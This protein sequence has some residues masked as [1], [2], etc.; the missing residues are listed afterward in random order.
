MVATHYV[1]LLL[2]LQ[3]GKIGGVRMVRSSSRD[4]PEPPLAYLKIS[5]GIFHDMLCHD[6]DMLH[7]LTGEVPESV[8]S[9]AHTHNPEIGKMDD[10]DTVIVTMKSSSGL[11]ATVDTSRISAYGYD[12]RIEVFGEKGM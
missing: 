12:Q 9:V 8:Y 10:A 11:L 2:S 1:S 5:G 3:A 6:F 4:N 7:F